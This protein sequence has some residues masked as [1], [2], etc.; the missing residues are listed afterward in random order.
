MLTIVQY[1]IRGDIARIDGVAQSPVYFLVRPLGGF[2]CALVA[3]KPLLVQDIGHLYA[4]IAP[5]VFIKHTHDDE[6]FIGNNAQ[7]TLHALIAEWRSSE[8]VKPFASASLSFFACTLGNHLSLH[9]RKYAQQV[10]H[11]TPEVGA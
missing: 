9:F 2:S 11:T 10:T 8:E 7:L 1:V 3:Q 4:T 5:V 6:R